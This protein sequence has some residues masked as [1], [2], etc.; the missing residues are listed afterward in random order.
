MKPE[1]SLSI[2]NIGQESRI[3]KSRQLQLTKANWEAVDHTKDKYKENLDQEN[4]N[5]TQ[6]W[7]AGKTI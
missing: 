1:C 4:K 3:W 2:N 7:I 6:I 5:P